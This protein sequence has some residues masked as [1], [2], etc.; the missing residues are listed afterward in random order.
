L[1]FLI[2]IAQDFESIFDVI[3]LETF[4][5]HSGIYFR[6]SISPLILFKTLLNLKWNPDTI[7]FGVSTIFG[8]NFWCL[9]EPHFF[10]V[11]YFSS[12][13]EAC[14]EVLLEQ[15]VNE[16][17]SEYHASYLKNSFTTS[18]Q[19]DSNPLPSIFDSQHRIFG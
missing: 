14:Q 17:M 9:C 18:G 13:Q 1:V 2:Q 12:K 6:H 5:D 3:S 16:I 8:V 19:Q 4:F 7:F 11:Y 10:R 15:E